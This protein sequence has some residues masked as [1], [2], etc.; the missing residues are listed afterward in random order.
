MAECSRIGACNFFRI[1][2]SQMPT[3]VKIFKKSFCT[4]DYEGCAR[5]R[6]LNFIE[7][8]NF[9]VS[10]ETAMMIDRVSPTLAPDE[11]EKIKHL[12]SR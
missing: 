12:I 6:L 3:T 7:G 1:T 5:H 11:L 4:D 9:D 8:S 10:E 2:L